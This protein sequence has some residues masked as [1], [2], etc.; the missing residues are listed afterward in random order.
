MIT[1]YLTSDTSSGKKELFVMRAESG[2]HE[3]KSGP[4]YA[5]NVAWR[6]CE[7]AAHAAAERRGMNAE[8]TVT[9]EDV[10][11][12]AQENGTPASSAAW[13]VS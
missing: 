13:V 9:P 4:F 3:T 6:Q 10:A 5:H 2:T 1:F 7:N 12:Q 11:V 8:Y